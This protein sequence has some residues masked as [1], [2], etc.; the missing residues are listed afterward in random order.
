MRILYIS[1]GNHLDYQ[2][3][4]LSIGLKELFGAS[5]VDV[6]KREHLYTTFPKEKAELMYGKGMTVTRILE[7]Y[8]VDRSDIETKIAKRYFDLIVFGSVAR[9]SLHLQLAVE[10]YPKSKIFVVDGEDHTNL[11]HA[12]IDFGL[13]YFKRE[14][15][16]DVPGVFPISF[17]I[18]SAKFSPN[19]LKSREIAI[20]DPRDRNSYIYKSE[21]DYYDGYKESYF[22]YTTKKAGWDCMRHYEIM[23]NGCLPLF[24]DIKDCPRQTMTTFNKELCKDILASYYG[25]TPIPTIYEKFQ[26]TAFREFE[27]NNTTIA[28]AKYIYAKYKDIN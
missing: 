17:A 26:E 27:K 21:T 23:A 3:D 4:C 24:L 12:L 6:N 28:L 25:R 5:V 15:T 10:S 19:S 22:A 11:Y 2:D 9:C 18:P 16:I 8:D 13:P 14:L 20:C 7:D 1:A